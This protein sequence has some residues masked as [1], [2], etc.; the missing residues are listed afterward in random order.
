MVLGG[1]D[2]EEEEDRQTTILGLEGDVMRGA[3]VFTANCGTSDCHGADGQGG[4]DS[5][6]PGIPAPLTDLVPAREDEAIVRVMLDGLGDMT[7]QA[8]LTDQQ[9]ADV[10]AYVNAEFGP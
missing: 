5:A 10:L 9:L 3:T 8:G 6:T 7:S 2:G 4:P 1:C